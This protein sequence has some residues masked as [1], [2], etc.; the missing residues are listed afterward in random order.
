MIKDLRQLLQQI[1][2]PDEVILTERDGK[3]PNYHIF[4]VK[5]AQFKDL[6]KNLRDVRPEHGRFDIFINGQWILEQDYI[7]EQ[8][9]KDILVKFKKANFP[10]TL[11]SAD[12]ITIVGD[13]QIDG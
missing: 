7:L 8:D 13:I 4:E 5:D 3:H 10:Y 12:R 6:H 1:H 2:E 11:S 9:D